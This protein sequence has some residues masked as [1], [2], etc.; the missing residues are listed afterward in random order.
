[1]HESVKNFLIIFIFTLFSVL[2]F[3]GYD[4]FISDQ[5]IYLPLVYNNL[6]NEL[7]SQ[8]I[9]LKFD[10]LGYS[11]F[12]EIIAFFLIF[13]SN[14]SLILFLVYFVS[15]FFFFYAIYRLAFY[16]TKDKNFSLLSLL[17]FVPTISVYGTQ[18]FDTLLIPRVMGIP[19]GLLSLVYFLEK[20][21]YVSSVLLSL[22][23]LIHPMTAIYFLGFFYLN[24]L[25]DFEN[26][27]IFNKKLFIPGLFPVILFFV[28]SLFGGP[29]LGFFTL[30]D[31]AWEKIILLRWSSFFISGW[32][33]NL[34]IVLVTG[35]I[36]YLIGLEAYKNKTKKIHLIVL[37]LF[38]LLLAVASLF[39]SD[40]LKLHFIA[41]LQIYRGLFF[42]KILGGILFFR[43]AY[44]YINRKPKDYVYIFFML[45]TLFALFINEDLIY[46]FFYLFLCLWIK[47]KYVP[48]FDAF[49]F[50]KDIIFLLLFIP[51]LFLF[52]LI[53]KNLPNFSVIHLI[54]VLILSTLFTFITSFRERFPFNSS[55]VCAIFIVSILIF[56][57]SFSFYSNYYRDIE[58]VFA[59]NWIN[60]NTEKDSVFITFPDKLSRPIRLLCH[61][62]IFV[63]GREGS[64]SL[65]NRDF[66]FEWKKRMDLHLTIKANPSFTGEVI[67]NYK[68]DY[69]FSD[70]EI[71]FDYPLVYNNS[72]YYVYEL[73]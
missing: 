8:D 18:L 31:S 14:V 73:K 21:Y 66:A 17:I 9:I 46:P 53:V 29:G 13:T 37:L 48:K 6:D 68:I 61:R 23:Y 26:K 44:L 4:I 56:I 63:S 25:F 60:E 7:F 49:I 30:I 10:V 54:I 34:F 40:I 38:S 16:F 62:S 45:G 24:L 15:K 36:L 42:I 70:K 20:K 52:F 39:L 1:M 65:F 3:P 69:L 32:H 72:L 22:H 43:M 50:K 58:L 71:N 41:Q 59:C 35:I 19:L 47:R 12:D 55:H 51:I 67:E 28:T 5:E 57:P 11:L 27:K 33:Y 2:V 64:S